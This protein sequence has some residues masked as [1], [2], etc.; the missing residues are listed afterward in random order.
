M[1]GQPVVSSLQFHCIGKDRGARAP[2]EMII[3][4]GPEGDVCAFEEC[5]GRSCKELCQDGRDRGPLGYAM[6]W[7]GSSRAAVSI[8][9]DGH[10]A[11]RNKGHG[12]VH[13]FSG[14][15]EFKE[16]LTQVVVSHIVKEPLDIAGKD[17]IH[18][19]VLPCFLYVSDE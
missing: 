1:G 15:L 19:M 9:G 12:P 7:L 18:L 2:K 11:V 16:G 5:K 3:H 14:E 13:Q 6:V 10:S 4:K 8:E 17:G